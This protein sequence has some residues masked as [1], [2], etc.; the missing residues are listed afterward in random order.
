MPFTNQNHGAESVLPAHSSEYIPTRHNGYHSSGRPVGT[1]PIQGDLPEAQRQAGGLR[2]GLHREA[3]LQ[4][5]SSAL[6]CSAHRVLLSPPLR[7]SGGGSPVHK[8]QSSG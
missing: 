5:P 8:A 2:Q 7:G 6:Q 4:E 1:G 3:A